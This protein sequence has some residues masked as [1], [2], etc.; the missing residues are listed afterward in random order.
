VNNSGKTTVLEA[1]SLWQECFQK[2]IVE[3][4]K[5]KT[6]TSKRGD[7]TLVNELKKY[8]TFKEINSI[9]VPNFED[10]FHQLNKKI[11]FLYQ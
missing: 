3:V 4:K 11:V 7:Y 9:Q 10:I 5:N 8:F 2:L 1:L 6:T